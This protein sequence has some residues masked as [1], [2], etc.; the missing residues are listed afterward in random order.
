MILITNYYRGKIVENFHIGYA[1]A[2][3]ENGEELFTAGDGDYPI[4]IGAT[5]KPFLTATLYEAEVNKKFKITDEEMAL[6]CSSHNGEPAQTDLVSKI[7]KKSGLTLENLQCG[8]HSPLDKLSWE[9]LIIQGRRPTVLHNENSGTHAGMLAYAKVLD[10]N[11]ENYF[12]LDHPI[13]KNFLSK[14]KEYS[15]KEKVPTEVGNSGA[16]TYFMPLKN[17]AM[18]YNKLVSGNDKILDKV[19]HMM[20]LNSKFIAGKSRFDTDFISAMN[21]KAVSK[22]GFEGVRA[23]GAKTKAGNPVGIAL[24]VLSGNTQAADS[25]AITI[26]KNLNLIDNDVSS[27]LSKYETPT[28]KNHIDKKIGKIETVIKKDNV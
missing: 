10:A 24:K 27:K 26:M 4:Y 6:V 9:Q 21:G 14:I 7:L 12:S 11:L 18:M 20:S 28:I 25:M 19:Y 13:Q 5:A 3:D 23:I 1:V 2:V 8:V 22:T 15:G 17:L 16:P